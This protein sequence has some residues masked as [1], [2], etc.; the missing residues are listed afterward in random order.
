ME[1]KKAR[2]CLF[3]TAGLLP[4]CFDSLFGGCLCNV[5]FLGVAF[6]MVLCDVLL[7]VMPCYVPGLFGGRRDSLWI[8]AQVGGMPFNRCSLCRVCAAG[9]AG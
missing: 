8:C 4:T 3:G 6:G 7:R 5:M 9:Y 1:Q 2:Q